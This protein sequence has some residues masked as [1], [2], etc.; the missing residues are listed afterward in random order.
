[1]RPR[2][3]H[4]LHLAGL[5]LLF[6]FFALTAR[7]FGVS[8]AVWVFLPLAVLFECRFWWKLFKPGDDGDA[9]GSDP[10]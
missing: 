2:T 9:L 7:S 10:S 6:Y 1:M 8:V 5:A 3:Q 4:L